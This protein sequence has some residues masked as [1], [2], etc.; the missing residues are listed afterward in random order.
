MLKLKMPD[1][2]FVGADY[3]GKPFTGDDLE[4]DNIV[5]YPTSNSTGTDPNIS[6]SESIPA[7]N[8]IASIAV[9]SG[10]TQLPDGSVTIDSV[11][12][13]ASQTDFSISFDVILRLPSTLKYSLCT[14]PSNISEKSL[15]EPFFFQI[16]F[17]FWPFAS[18]T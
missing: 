15:N 11:D 18:M 5:L 7:H 9:F 1:I 2:R 6:F 12:G 13:N 16:T 14:E 4:I 17:L 8:A 10:S 3:H